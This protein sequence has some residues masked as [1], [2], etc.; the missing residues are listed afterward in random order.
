MFSSKIFGDMFNIDVVK[1]SMKKLE[2]KKK[3]K[4]SAPPKKSIGE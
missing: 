2:K 4:K 3:K 1:Q